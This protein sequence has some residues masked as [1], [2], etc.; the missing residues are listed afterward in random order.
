[1]EGRKTGRKCQITSEKRAKSGRHNADMPLV[2]SLSL[3][4]WKWKCWYQYAPRSGVADD[5]LFFLPASYHPRWLIAGLQMGLSRASCAAIGELLANY[6]CSSAFMHS[7]YYTSKRA[8][9]EGD[10][11]GGSDRVSLFQL[12]A[13][14][15]ASPG[16]HVTGGFFPRCKQLGKRFRSAVCDVSPG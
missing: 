13:V 8:S 16:D 4:G 12:P 15:D 11:V 2:R 10:V 5:C 14:G 9:Q 6:T 1:M 7:F 3:A